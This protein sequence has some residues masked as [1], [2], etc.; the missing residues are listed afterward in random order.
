MTKAGFPL[1]ADRPYYIDMFSQIINDVI[2]RSIREKAVVLMSWDIVGFDPHKNDLNRVF[3]SALKTLFKMLNAVGAAIVVS[4]P[5]DIRCTGPPCWF[6]DPGQGPDYMHWVIS[7]GPVDINTGR[8]V[9]EF[10]NRD[11]STNIYGPAADSGSYPMDFTCPDYAGTGNNPLTY[12][13]TSSATAFL[14][15]LMAY[16]K[17][18]GLSDQASR[19]KL[20]RD[21]YAR[22]PGEPK[23]IW[24]GARTGQVPQT[25]GACAQH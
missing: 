12:D 23:Y 9:V 18:L 7:V 13:G 19:G 3:Y 2:Y 24:N 17:G 8:M 20:W 6:S 5:N 22:V 11:V 10:P 4:Q 21:A 25:G 1:S 15:G 14:A 16:Y